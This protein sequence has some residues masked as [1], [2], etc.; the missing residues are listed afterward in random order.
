[1]EHIGE[2]LESVAFWHWLTFGAV[3][4]AI[5]IISETTYLLWPGIGALIVGAIKLFWPDMDGALALLLFAIFSV[6]ATWQWKRTPWS[7]AIRL[8]HATLNERTTQY[9]GRRVIAAEDF[10]GDT[11]AVLVDDTRWNARCLDGSPKKGD[12]LTIVSADGALFQ[13]RAT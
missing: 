10:T 3:L 2:F 6:V 1:M 12:A 5:E 9:I 4:I 13:V 11:G 8:T 7:K